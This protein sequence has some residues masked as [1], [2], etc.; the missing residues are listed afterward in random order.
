MRRNPWLLRSSILLALFGV[1]AIVLIG[2]LEK[3]GRLGGGRLLTG[4]VY[5]NLGILAW[6]VS[7]FAVLA[8]LC[9]WWRHNRAQRQ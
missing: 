8:G 4:Q 3:D 9:A 5:A 7:P 1:V 2:T 6:I